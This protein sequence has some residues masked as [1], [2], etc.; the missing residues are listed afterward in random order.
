MY[1]SGQN[2]VKT[3]AAK[4]VVDTVVVTSYCAYYD[5][6]CISIYEEFKAFQTFNVVFSLSNFAHTIYYMYN[7]SNPITK[8][9]LNILFILIQLRFHTH[10]QKKFLNLNSGLLLLI[11]I[12]DLNPL[13][14]I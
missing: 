6:C 13:K 1:A 3:D 7:G 5:F 10:T 14:L 8:S 4:I 11:K 2:Y 9:H 12:V